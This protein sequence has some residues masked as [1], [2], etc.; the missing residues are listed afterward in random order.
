MLGLIPEIFRAD[1]EPAIT[2]HPENYNEPDDFDMLPE[3]VLDTTT[4]FEYGSVAMHA[5]VSVGWNIG[6]GL[7]CY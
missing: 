7:S 4:E 3:N 2:M 6:Y 1:R 5:S